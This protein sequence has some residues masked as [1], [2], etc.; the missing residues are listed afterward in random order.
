M[1]ELEQDQGGGGDTG[2]GCGTETIRRRALKVTFSSALARSA[3][4]WIT[5]L[6]ALS[7]LVSSP[8]LGFLIG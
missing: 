1:F 5:A 2:D 4:P 6:N 8:S 7:R 3:T